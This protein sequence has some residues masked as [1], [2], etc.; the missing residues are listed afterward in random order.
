MK[1]LLFVAFIALGLGLVACGEKKDFFAIS[2]LVVCN[3]FNNDIVDK[4]LLKG[5]ETKCPVCNLFY[6]SL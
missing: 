5:L 4:H 6:R 3:Q 1:N 2:L